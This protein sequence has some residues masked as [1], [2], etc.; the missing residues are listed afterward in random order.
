MINAID[1]KNRLHGQ[2]EAVLL[3]LL[4]NGKKM[5]KEWKVG[6]L[7]GEPG[8]SLGVVLT[9]AKIGVW[10]DFA[11]DE[12][13]DILDLWKAVRDLGFREMF[14]EAC[15]F[16]GL[17]NVEPMRKKEKPP[18]PEVAKLPMRGSRVHEYLQG[19]GLGDQVL[20]KYRVRTLHHAG[21]PDW[22]AWSLH[23]WED[24]RLLEVKA[25]HIDL[26]E[27]HKKQIWSTPPYHTLFGWWTVKDTDRAVCITEGEIDCLSVDQMMPGIPV[28]SMP[29][30]V[31]NLEWIE[32]DYDRLNMFERIYVLTDSDKPGEECAQKIAHRLGLARTYRVKI[33]N[34]AGCKDAND[35][36]MRAAD[37]EENEINAAY[38]IN[39]AQT[40]APETIREAKSLA[41]AMKNI[42]ARQNSNE[43]ATFVFPSIN[44]NIRDGETTIL[45]G[46]PFGGKSNLLYQIL[47]HE[48]E[49]NDERVLVGS[50]EIN[51]EEIAFEMARMRYGK[52]MTPE[53]IDQV[54]EWLNDRCFF[55]TPDDPVSIDDLWRDMDYAAARYG[56]TR[57]AFDSLHFIVPKDE[58][59]FQDDF[60]RKLHRKTKSMDV[61]TILI[62]HAG[63]KSKGVDRIPGLG[64]VGGSD[65]V[66][67]PVDN[68]ITMWR[69]FEK[70]QAIDE[71]GGSPSDSIL[72][73]PDAVFSIWKQRVTGV[74]RNYNLWFDPERKLFRDTFHNPMKSETG[75]K[76]IF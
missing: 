60:V 1:L 56:C 29:S 2:I 20:I 76:E 65:G 19:R 55:L 38:W 12:T 73:M 30:G 49:H 22:I 51:S 36:L 57:F 45:S 53:N 69:N 43:K 33:P 41:R 59:V 32:N 26:N 39:E 11:T 4:P 10:K 23:D 13:G 44:F 67:K 58:Y 46:Y 5:G 52:G 48:M 21:S 50:Y 68:G 9:G 54:C 40:Y 16:V 15:R 17:T 71:A 63:I 25:T 61:A 42:L 34:L 31:S 74:E 37:L 3:H 35:I 72:N 62:A 27:K 18:T 66:V 24:D 75:Q 64:D 8:E 47:L 6:G 28:L 14:D 7:S 70:K